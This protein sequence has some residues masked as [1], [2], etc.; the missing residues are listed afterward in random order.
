MEGREVVV[1]GREV[2]VEGRDVVVEGREVVVEGREV[3]MEGQK[4]VAEGQ[5]VVAEG[6]EVVVVQ[7]LQETIMQDQEAVHGHDP[8]SGGVLARVEGTWS[9]EE[10]V[11]VA[12]TYTLT[13][14]LSSQNSKYVTACQLFCCFFVD[15]MWE[16][17]VVETHQ[18]A[19]SNTSTAP[20]PLSSSRPLANIFSKRLRLCGMHNNEKEAEIISGR[21]LS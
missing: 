4:V 2:V 13:P 9:K 19:A 17:L 6:Q 11:A 21:T 7:Q 8:T 12:L 10:P 5:K 18:Y 14:G 20:I 15:A 3:V 16:L 1:E